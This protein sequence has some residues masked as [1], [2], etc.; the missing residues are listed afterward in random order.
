MKKALARLTYPLRQKISS[1][2][3]GH[4]PS[5]SSIE[6][7]EGDVRRLQAGWSQHI[8][9]ILDAISISEH[10]AKASDDIHAR[11]DALR[12]DLDRLS[13]RLSASCVGM[14]KR[15]SELESSSRK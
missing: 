5:T 2:G 12:H 3:N 4:V 10:E 11:I 13:D 8:P 1:R 14:E 7:L 9:R 6:R 15:L